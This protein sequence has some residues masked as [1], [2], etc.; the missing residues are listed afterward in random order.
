[1]QALVGAK[2]TSLCTY[3]V[4]SS[5]IVSGTIRFMSVAKLS[6]EAGIQVPTRPKVTNIDLQIFVITIVTR[7]FYIFVTFYQYV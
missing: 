6:E 5:L 1:V 7:S 2:V 3:N 4:L